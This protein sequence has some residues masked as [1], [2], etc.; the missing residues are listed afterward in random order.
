[1][2]ATSGIQVI[3][4]YAGAANDAAAVNVLLALIPDPD[5][6]ESPNPRNAGSMLDEMSPFAAAQLRVELLALRDA[7]DTTNTL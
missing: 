6:R 1:M 5:V 4:N 2:S 3:G 7:V